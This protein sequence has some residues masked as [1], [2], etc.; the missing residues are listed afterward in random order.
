[1]PIPQSES[2]YSLQVS[3]LNYWYRSL[4]LACMLADKEYYAK[5]TKLFRRGLITRDELRQKLVSHVY[6]ELGLV[7]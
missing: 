3:W 6:V 5:I 2:E 1:M 4:A 7:V